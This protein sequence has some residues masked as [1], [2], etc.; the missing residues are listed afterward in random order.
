M[1]QR[2]KQHLQQSFYGSGSGSSNSFS[3]NSGGSGSSSP[4]VRRAHG[5]TP[6]NLLDQ[7]PEL[8]VSDSSS[9]SGASPLNTWYFRARGKGGGEA[10]QTSAIELLCA[11]QIALDVVGHAF[12]PFEV[13]A[14]TWCD[15][16]ADFIWGLYR[17]SQR[18]KCK[19]LLINCGVANETESE[20][21]K[22]AS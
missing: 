1:F 4:S 18:C 7:H 9:S 12:L 22:D 6:S 8:N 5:S 21:V 14:P 11:Q 20:G 16:C 17:A 2:L 13:P 19:C 15:Q 10:N 3:G